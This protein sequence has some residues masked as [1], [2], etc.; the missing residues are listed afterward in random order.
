MAQLLQV[1]ELRHVV[2][3]HPWLLCSE[4][5]ATCGRAWGLSSATLTA[6]NIL[7]LSNGATSSRAPTASQSSLSRQHPAWP[8]THAWLCLSASL[9][10]I[11]DFLKNTRHI[12]ANAAG[13]MPTVKWWS[14]RRTPSGKSLVTLPGLVIFGLMFVFSLFS[15]MG[16]LATSSTP[17]GYMDAP[18]SC[19]TGELYKHGTAS[20]AP[21]VASFHIS[22]P[23]HP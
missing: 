10:Q 16:R 6:H 8:R 22:E 3:G 19:R 17:Q 9:H 20:Q 23:K 7:G 4:F 21:A 11:P 2:T 18:C 1:T 12:F 15:K 5:T 14:W 13:N